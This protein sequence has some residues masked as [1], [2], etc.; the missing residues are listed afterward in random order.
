MNRKNIFLFASIFIFI[1]VGGFLYA[2]RMSSYA[3][4]VSEIVSKNPV[5][6]I[7]NIKHSVFDISVE[8]KDDALV[9]VVRIVDG[10]TIVVSENGAEEK[11][12]L[13]GID[14]PETVDP[15]KP[16]QC[17]GAE[18]SRETKELLTNQQVL[19]KSDSSQGDRDKYGRLLRYVYLTD[20]TFIN[21]S[22]VTNGYARE[23]TYRAPYQFQ[24]E[25]KS[26]ESSARAERLGLW[27]VCK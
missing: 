1:I 15:Y 8:T 26:A 19:L 20:G 14:A 2:I 4:V 10:D 27:G 16:V 13:I 7:A 24:S 18:A 11:V 5:G 9:L 23:Y 21:L 12:R 6:Q 17:F 25:F 22:L 3:P